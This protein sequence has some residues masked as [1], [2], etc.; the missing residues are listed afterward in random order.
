[1]V[2]CVFSDADRRVYERVLASGE[3]A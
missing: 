3:P 1:V 2:L